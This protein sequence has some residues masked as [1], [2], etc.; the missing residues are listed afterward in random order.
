[1][2]SSFL[3]LATPVLALTDSL[4]RR[5][6]QTTGPD[7][8]AWQ[9]MLDAV[10][11]DLGQALERFG[12]DARDAGKTE[13]AV[14]AARFA[15][16][17]VIETAA[18]RAPGLDGMAWA[19][20]ARGTIYAGRAPETALLTRALSVAEGTGPARDADL[21]ALLRVCLRL[22]GAEAEA[23][24]AATKSPTAPM[25]GG[26]HG[27]AALREPPEPHPTASPPTPA[28][29]RISLR[30]IGLVV[31]IGAAIAGGTAAMLGYQQA[32]EAAAQ[33]TLSTAAPIQQIRTAATPGAAVDAAGAL[34]AQLQARV[35]AVR[36]GL[37][38]V[39]GAGRINAAS[40]AAQ[41]AMAT[42]L[43]PR[44]AEAASAQGPG[45]DL[46]HRIVADLLAG[47][48]P[49]DAAWLAGF[50]GTLPGH[51]IDAD[52]LSALATAVLAAPALDTTAG[53][54]GEAP[55]VGPVVTEAA[56]LLAISRDP[57]MSAAGYWSLSARLPDAPRAFVQRSGAGVEGAPRIPALFTAPGAALLA[58]DPEA[59]TRAAEDR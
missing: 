39:V 23:P 25:K 44:L 56:L 59:L 9:G 6:A 12:A 42:A 50:M 58:E 57:V 4:P 37:A 26:E 5:L 10:L 29:R 28:R 53:S 36:T 35:A 20:A 3:A 24:S 40:M 41:A 17:C 15:L 21:A 38:A 34:E 52:T 54:E 31:A 48:V 14:G 2:G 33:L 51:S 32:G 47:R 13:N 8:P 7:A 11:A 19:A 43:K 16:T 49:P 55:T 22:A 45:E 18:R 27:G 46:D 1:M 30:T